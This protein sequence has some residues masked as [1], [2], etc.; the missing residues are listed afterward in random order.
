MLE[1]VAG[2]VAPAATMIAALMTAANLGARVT[3]WGFVVFTLGSIAW[4]IIGLA[5][6]QTSL[7]AAN[8]FLTI[9]NLFGIW[10]WLGREAKYQAIAET[11]AAK[12]DTAPR[13]ALTPAGK[14]IGQPVT[15]ERGEARANIVD[16]MIARDDGRIH[17]LLVRHG[18]GPGGIGERVVMLDDNAF[19]LN[20]AGVVTKL[21]AEELA[22]LPEVSPA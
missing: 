15:D 2:W 21:D 17:A 7:I 11:I 18:G 16:A 8:A 9:V 1:A 13:P 4:T 19:S 3:G 14:L 12:S 20:S 6:G 5:S 10:R 22:R